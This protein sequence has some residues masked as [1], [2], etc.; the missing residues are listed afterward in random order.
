MAELFWNRDN[1]L[2]KIIT[3]ALIIGTIWFL[4]FR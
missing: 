3:A 2:G 4:F 1:W